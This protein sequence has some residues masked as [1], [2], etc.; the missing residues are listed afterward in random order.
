MYR[1]CYTAQMHFVTANFKVFSNLY[2]FPFLNPDSWL[3][4]ELMPQTSHP[5]AELNCHAMWTHSWD[6]F[7]VTHC[8]PFFHPLHCSALSMLMSTWTSGTAVKPFFKERNPTCLHRR[9]STKKF[10]NWGGRS[11]QRRAFPGARFVEYISKPRQG[12]S[13]LSEKQGS[14]SAT[15]ELNV[16]V[17]RKQWRYSRLTKQV[18]GSVPPMV[19]TLLQDSQDCHS[20]QQ[21][22][23]IQHIDSSR[24]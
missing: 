22:N 1:S 19:P 2:F 21:M 13:P 4:R 23:L 6:M 24:P 7:R 16:E 9:R 14:A 5:D 10:L 17:K 11:V 3:G 12:I 8:S 20:S 18:F 15:T